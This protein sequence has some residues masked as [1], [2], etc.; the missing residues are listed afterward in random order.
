MGSRKL[1]LIEEVGQATYGKLWRLTPAGRSHWQRSPSLAEA[2][3]PP[4]M[5]RSGRIANVLAYLAEH[6]E[7]RTIEVA[8]AFEFPPQS[9]N[10][11]MQHLKR[12]GMVRAQSDAFRSPYVLTDEGRDLLAAMTRRAEAT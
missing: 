7:A 3:E 10:A 5:Y 12:R 6:G 8:R 2:A 1:G 4:L 11:L 9:T